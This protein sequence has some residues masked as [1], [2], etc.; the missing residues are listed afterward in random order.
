MRPLFKGDI[1]QIVKC[2]F[3]GYGGKMDKTKTDSIYITW[4]LNRLFSEYPWVVKYNELEW[5]DNLVCRLADWLLNED[6]KAN[7]I[8]VS[9]P[10]VNMVR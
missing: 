1:S 5:F 4:A 2:L 6:I 7:I 8:R 9:V 10:G 3:R